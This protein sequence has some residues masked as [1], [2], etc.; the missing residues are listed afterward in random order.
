M[1]A[2]ARVK[3]TRELLP[4]HTTYASLSKGCRHNAQVEKNPRM[5]DPAHAS[6]TV[7]LHGVIATVASV[8]GSPQIGQ[9]VPA[10][11]VI[12]RTKVDTLRVHMLK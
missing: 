5:R 6:H 12:R 9:S 1:I 8:N 10:S 4:P 3:N 7:W 2:F 11:A